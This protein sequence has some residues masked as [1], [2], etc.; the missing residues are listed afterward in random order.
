MALTET[1]SQKPL[2]VYLVLVTHALIVVFGFYA[3]FLQI[4]NGEK[5]KAQWFLL[6]WRSMRSFIY[7]L[8]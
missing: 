4:R 6:L 3:G 2:W 1:D 8:L 7:S 5:K